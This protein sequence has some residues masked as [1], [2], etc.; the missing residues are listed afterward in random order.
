MHVAALAFVAAEELLDSAGQLRLQDIREH[1]ER[2]TRRSRRLRQLLTRPRLG[3]GPP[4]WTDDPAFDVALHVNARPVPAP[5]D[6]ASVLALCA[7]LNEPALARS[8]P[9]WEMWLLTGL[10][11]NR[12]ALL[13]RLHHAAADGVAAQNLL[14]ALFDPDGRT[15]AAEV[16][17]APGGIQPRP[18]DW[19]LFTAN[20]GDR[21]RALASFLTA[22]GHPSRLAG[23]IAQAA[24][25]VMSL[26]RMG[27][28]PAVSL[29]EPVGPRRRLILV[30]G[31]LAVAKALAHRCGAKLTDVLLAAYA[32]GCM[33][34]LESR[35]ELTPELELKVSV[36]ASLR[37]ADETTSGNRVGVRIV[38]IPVAEPD[39]ARRLERISEARSAQLNR[40]PLQPGNRLLQRWMVRVM[41][42]QRLVNLLLSNLP[43][44]PAPVYFAGAKVLEMFQI[45]VV[46]GNIP[47]G[48]SVLSYAGQLNMVVVADPDAVPDLDVFSRGLSDSFEQLQTDSPDS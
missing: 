35:G 36:A 18:T 38:P 27:R 6:E 21:G 24:L 13:I 16:D 40:P 1:V 4:F 3:L 37:G 12:T 33:R 26:V 20:A 28:A 29:N 8:R 39:P 44:P 41:F 10:T 31:D 2:R 5:G 15:S 14:A 48:V 23:P 17:E 19:Q 22:L 47:I 32:G 9:L 34:L 25:Q 7:E 45:G 11:G 46:Q 42:R 43:G 30:R